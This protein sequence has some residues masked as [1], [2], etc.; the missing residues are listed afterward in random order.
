M[1]VA[2]WRHALRSEWSFIIIISQAMPDAWPPTP[3]IIHSQ[4]RTLKASVP[5]GLEPP[6]HLA[7]PGPGQERL[8]CTIPK[9]APTADKQPEKQLPEKV[10][11]GNKPKLPPD[12]GPGDE[13]HIIDQ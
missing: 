13:P 12:V 3:G 5:P 8:V 11:K 6:A 2:G 9:H 4:L 7:P 1:F 10:D